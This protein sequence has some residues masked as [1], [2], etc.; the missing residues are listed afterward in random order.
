MAMG[1]AAPVMEEVAAR[2][3]QAFGRPDAVR[4]HIS[5]LGG[6]VAELATPQSRATVALKGAQVLSWRPQGR[7]E[8]L[9]LSPAARLDGPKAVRGGIPVCWPWFGPHPSDASAPAHGLVRTAPWQIAE[10]EHSAGSASVTLA[11]NVE[12]DETAFWPHAARVSLRVEAGEDLRLTLT[13]E[14]TGDAPFGLTAALHSYFAIGDIAAVEIT[15][16]EHRDF[17]D[18]LQPGKTIPAGQRPV[19]FD[20]E[21][22][23]IYTSAPED[24][25]IRDPSLRRMIRIAKSNSPSTVVWNPWIE[26]S[27]RLGDLGEDGYRRMVCVETARIGCDAAR[28]APGRSLSMETCLSVEPLV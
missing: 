12:P 13:T 21:T 6:V 7:D 10:S 28:I 25:L 23:R 15:G 18:Q 26:K 19:R 14:N 8:V 1:E 24:V 9:W 16:L 4:F 5:P 3:E 11:F 27:E 17:I 20:R 22:D 2:L